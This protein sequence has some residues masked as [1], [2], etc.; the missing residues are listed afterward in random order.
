MFLWH[1]ISR[2]LHSNA[3]LDVVSSVFIVWT[4]VKAH[5]V[6]SH[7]NVAEVPHIVRTIVHKYWDVALV[8]VI[9]DVFA[10]EEVVSVLDCNVCVAVVVVKDTD[11][12]CDI[13]FDY[14][15]AR[16]IEKAGS[17]ICTAMT[18]TI[19]LLDGIPK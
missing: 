16:G 1:P 15:I 19:D 6:V 18:I 13:V 7:E 3:H 4:H 14:L 9:E 17:S 5:V 2:A 8:R 12:S 11:L 10:L